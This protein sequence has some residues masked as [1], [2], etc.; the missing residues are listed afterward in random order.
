MKTQR[1]GTTVGVEPLDFAESFDDGPGF[2]EGCGI[3]S[4]DA[5]APLKLLCGE[6]GKGLSSASGW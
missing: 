5:G 1:Y 2:F 6:S 4:Y 3:I